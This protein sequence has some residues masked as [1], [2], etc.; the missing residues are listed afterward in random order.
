MWFPTELFC[1]EQQLIFAER[2]F[3]EKRKDG[4]HGV[5]NHM[6]DQGSWKVNL[7]FPDICK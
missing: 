6:T 5:H 7:A 2:A 4:G 3:A 1:V